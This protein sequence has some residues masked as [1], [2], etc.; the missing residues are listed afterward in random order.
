MKEEYK[1]IAK[2]FNIIPKYKN[3]I[4]M[5]TPG[6]RKNR[7]IALDEYTHFENNM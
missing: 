1:I 4:G 3:L 7:F 6:T 2:W 5:C